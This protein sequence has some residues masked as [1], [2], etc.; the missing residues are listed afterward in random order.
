MSVSANLTENTNGHAQPKVIKHRERRPGIKMTSSL[1]AD[2][3]KQVEQ[4]DRPLL[5]STQVKKRRGPNGELVVPPRPPVVENEALAAL[6]PLRDPTIAKVVLPAVKGLSLWGDHGGVL[7]LVFRSLLTHYSTSSLAPTHE[8]LL[9][10][11]I[12]GGELE[13]RDSL[14]EVHAYR[15]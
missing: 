12:A 5:P 1:L 14:E 10:H 8:E 11:A 2:E 13:G 3:Q 15:P 4:P 6:A 9:M 7:N